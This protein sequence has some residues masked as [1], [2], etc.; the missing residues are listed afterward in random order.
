MLLTAKEARQKTGEI[1]DAKKARE[2]MRVELA[3]NEAM[4]SGSYLC[5]I[6]GFDPS[7]EARKALKELG[8]SVEVFY[9]DG[10]VTT[11]IKW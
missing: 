3:I 8:Y 9:E 6:H 2:L 11:Q 1:N 7:L 10:Y 4:E 5:I